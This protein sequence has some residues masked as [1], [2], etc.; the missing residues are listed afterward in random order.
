MENLFLLLTFI[1]TKIPLIMVGKP[2]SS[3]T[4]S[5]SIIRDFLSSSNI[6]NKEI[7][8]KFRLKPIYVLS[9]QCNVSSKSDDINDRWEQTK[10]LSEQIKDIIHVL[11][12]DENGLAE[13]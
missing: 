4:L 11:F 7:L 1:Q 5:M 12:L 2:G 6:K 8:K 13:L 10:K 9:Y 3:N